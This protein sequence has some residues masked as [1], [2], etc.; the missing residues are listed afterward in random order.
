VVG[1]DGS[2]GAFAALVRALAEAARSGADVEVASAFPAGDHW[3]D[4]LPIDD[5]PAPGVAARV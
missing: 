3:N 1:V 5:E 4:P 2:P